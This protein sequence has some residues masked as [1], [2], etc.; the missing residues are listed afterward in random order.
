M[1]PPR[2]EYFPSIRWREQAKS[3]QKQIQGIL[4]KR[5]NYG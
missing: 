1:P 4:P 3:L 5:E 2:M